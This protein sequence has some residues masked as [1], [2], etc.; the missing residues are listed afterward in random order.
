MSRRLGSADF[1]PY[2]GKI[3]NLTNI[4][5]NGLVQPSISKDFHYEGLD[6]Y[7]QCKG[8][9]CFFFPMVEDL[10]ERL[11]FQDPEGFS[12]QN[13]AFKTSVC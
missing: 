12:R 13:A 11:F 4:F 3:S 10:F 2:L 9:M 1:H 8:W 7:P 6:A 5:Q